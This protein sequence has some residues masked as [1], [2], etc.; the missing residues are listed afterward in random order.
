MIGIG[1]TSSITAKEQLAPFLESLLEQFP[2]KLDI[3]ST[4]FERGMVFYAGL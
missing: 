2:G 1:C 4:G 3:C